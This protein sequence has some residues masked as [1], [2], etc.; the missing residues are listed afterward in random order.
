VF[1]ST[2]PNIQKPTDLFPFIRLLAAAILTRR[3][4]RP[5]AKTRKTRSPKIDVGMIRTCAD[6]LSKAYT[7]ASLFYGFFC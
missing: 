4:Q 2:S 7:L 6:V 5:Q 1:G 3:P